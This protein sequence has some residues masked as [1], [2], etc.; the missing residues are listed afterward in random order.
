M[1]KTA[2]KVM[3]KK[4]AQEKAQ[5]KKKP[6]HPC[7]FNRLNAIADGQDEIIFFDLIPGTVITFDGPAKGKVE[8]KKDS[9]GLAF[10]QPGRYEIKILHPDH[11]T[12]H[13]TAIVYPMPEK[14][15]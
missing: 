12:M 8:V 6:L 11:L 7:R 15:E 2:M 9:H 4:E 5:A 10:D 1:S 13:Y 3:S 14:E